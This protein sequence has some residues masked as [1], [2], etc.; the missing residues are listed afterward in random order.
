MYVIAWFGLI[1]IIKEL[2]IVMYKPQAVKMTPLTGTKFCS[3]N[4]TSLRKHLQKRYSM[5]TLVDALYSK[6][7]LYTQKKVSEMKNKTKK[8]I[9]AD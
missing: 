4:V 8:T 1:V 9:A 5:Y 6:S 3:F 7:F 2:L